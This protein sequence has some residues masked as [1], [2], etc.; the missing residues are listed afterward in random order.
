VSDESA[1]DTGVELVSMSFTR[2]KVWAGSGE[3]RRSSPGNTAGSGE[4]DLYA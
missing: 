4:V 2:E 1:E 3:D